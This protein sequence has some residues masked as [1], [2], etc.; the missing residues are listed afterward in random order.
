MSASSLVQWESELPINNPDYLLVS[1][2]EYTD[3]QNFNVKQFCPGY[4]D[5]RITK[6]LD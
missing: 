4:Q 5:I 2:S 3:Y 6:Q 1:S